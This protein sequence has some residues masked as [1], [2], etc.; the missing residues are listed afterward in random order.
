M[1]QLCA[2]DT[3]KR[4]TGKLHSRN[5]VAGEMRRAGKANFVLIGGEI[6]ELGRDIK[7]S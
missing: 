2:P 3:N 7:E 6:Q 4:M 1:E 5:E